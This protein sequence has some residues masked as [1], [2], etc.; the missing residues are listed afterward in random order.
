VIGAVLF[1]V[2]T[3]AAVFLGCFPDQSAAALDKI[4]Q[5]QKTK[6]E[7]KSDDWLAGSPFS[8]NK[9]RKTK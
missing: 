2:F 7:E 8:D 9:K 6:V 3:G 1:T 4:K 5:G